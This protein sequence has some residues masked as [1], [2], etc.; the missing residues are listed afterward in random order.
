MQYRPLG[1]SDLRVSHIGLGT[2]TWGEQ[3]DEAQ[4]HEQL[5]AALAAGVNFVDTAEMYPV[6]PRAET[7][8]RTEQIIG[9]WLARTARRHDIILASKVIGPGA[10][11]YVRGGPRLDRSEEHTS[12]LQSLMRISYAVFRLKKK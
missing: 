11:P 2:M 1:R 12:E 8:G 6:A 5:D 10:F 7:Y 3:N 4:A 9:S